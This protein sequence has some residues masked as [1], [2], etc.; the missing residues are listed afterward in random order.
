MYNLLY[1]FFGNF[2]CPCLPPVAAGPVSGAHRN[3]YQFESHLPDRD[4]TQKLHNKLYNVHNNNTDVLK[5]VRKVHHLY[6]RCTA[7]LAIGGPVTGQV[8]YT[9]IVSRV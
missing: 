6:I 1:K 7:Q 8:Q 9:S 2:Y 5:V 3:T 4:L